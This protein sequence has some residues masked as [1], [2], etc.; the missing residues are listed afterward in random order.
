M[1][2]IVIGAGPAGL[3]M[4]SYLED[5]LILEKETNVCSFFRYYPRQRTFISLNRSK[6]MKYDWNSFLD[7]DV[8]FRDYTEELYPSTDDYIKYAEDF[9][10]RKNLNIK[11]EYEVKRIEKK[12]GL[13]YIND[14]E[15]VCE[16]LFVGTGLTEKDYRHYFKVNPKYKHVYSY[17]NMPL[18]KNVYRDKNVLIVGTG[19]AAWETLDYVGNVSKRSIITGRNT[20]AWKTHFPG[21]ARL[22]NSSH[23][24]SFFLKS[25]TVCEFAHDSVEKYTDSDEYAILKEVVEGETDIWGHIDVIIF[26]IGFTFNPR[27]IRKFVEL[28]SNTGFPVMTQNFESTLTSNL[29]IIG[30]NT[31]NMDFKRGTSS[32]ITGFRYNCKHVQRYLT[33]IQSEILTTDE[34]KKTVFKQLNESSCLLHKFDFFCDVIEKLGE[35]QW[36]Y[37][38]EVPHPPIL[39]KNMFTIHLGYSVK[40]PTDSF[41]GKNIDAPS[42]AHIAPAIHPIITMSKGKFHLQ[43]DIITEFNSTVIHINPFNLFLNLFENKISYEIFQKKI[44]ELPIGRPHMD[45]TYFWNN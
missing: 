40:Y 8:S 10:K 19:N 17:G 42:F 44:I 20:F 26:C 13:F 11:F 4:A 12:D 32:F 33:G 36:R 3:Q 23:I 39:N 2:H 43:S 24:D 5:C 16:K 34:M 25:A 27:L 35:N 6:N 22:K 15:Y 28:D 31:Q 41:K 45:R 18:D 9:V 14:G 1:K 30:S 21:H 37:T 38:K 7:D 29:F